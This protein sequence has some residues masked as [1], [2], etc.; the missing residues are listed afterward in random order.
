MP[1]MKVTEAKKVEGPDE[2]QKSTAVLLDVKTDVCEMQFEG[3]GV[4]RDFPHSTFVF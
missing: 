3:V 1:A 4:L 2:G